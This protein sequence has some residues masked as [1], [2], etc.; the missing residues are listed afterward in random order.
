MGYLKARPADAKYGACYYE[1]Y[2]KDKSELREEEIELIKMPG[3]EDFDAIE[4]QVKV[5]KADN[6]NVYLYG[7]KSRFD[8][9]IPVIDDN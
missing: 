2:S 7:G 4:L 8:S 9:K 1:I 5:T 3:V 6:L